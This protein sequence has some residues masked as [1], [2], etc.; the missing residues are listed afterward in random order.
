[1]IKYLKLRKIQ[2]KQHGGKKLLLEQ[3]RRAK[4]KENIT[5]LFKSFAAHKQR[6]AFLQ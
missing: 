6:H 3:G 4:G 5:L 2:K 1:M